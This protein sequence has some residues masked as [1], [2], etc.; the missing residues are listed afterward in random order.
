MA[1]TCFNYIVVNKTEVIAIIMS[2]QIHFVLHLFFYFNSKIHRILPFLGSN[3]DGRKLFCFVFCFTLVFSMFHCVHFIHHLF[4]FMLSHTCVTLLHNLYILTH[5]SIFASI[6]VIT[7]RVSY[8]CACLF[9]IFCLLSD[10]FETHDRCYKFFSS[11][12]VFIFPNIQH[13]Y[14]I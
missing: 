4:F 9:L 11:L 12:S 5:L 7:F 3:E 1:C 10:R 8:F 13:F 2:F 6:Y 14:L